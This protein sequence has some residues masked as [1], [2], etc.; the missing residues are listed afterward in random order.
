MLA[1]ARE[2]PGGSIW[3]WDAAHDYSE[4]AEVLPWA[5]LVV[6]T[7]VRSSSTSHCWPV[8]RSAGWLGKGMKIRNDSAAETR[9]GDLSAVCIPHRV[10]LEAALPLLFDGGPFLALE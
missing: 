10:E 7:H 6:K 2:L 5:L 3:P 9:V 4:E 8:R 1:H